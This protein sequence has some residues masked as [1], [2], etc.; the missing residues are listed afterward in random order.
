M[1]SWE[2]RLVTA[3]EAVKVVKSGDIVALS[4]QTA[5]PVTLCKRLAAP[6]GRAQERSHRA[7]HLPA[8][9]GRNPDCKTPS[10]STRS[11]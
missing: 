5:T 3:E 10:F 4:P 11:M 1:E 2:A 9:P 6:E 7:P 8:T